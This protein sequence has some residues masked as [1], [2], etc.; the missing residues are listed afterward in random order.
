M[1]R[2]RGLS[3]RFT[4]WVL[5]VLLLT[6][7]GAAV[8]SMRAERQRLIEEARERALLLNRTADRAI[9]SAM[10]LGGREGAC[11]FVESLVTGHDID[12]V[13]II[14]QEGVVSL[15]PSSGEE[16]TTVPYHALKWDLALPGGG[17]DSVRV[18][19]L[20]DESGGLRV[21][22]IRPI[23]NQSQCWTAS[24]HAHNEDERVLGILD[25]GWYVE[26]F[27]GELWER[28]IGTV[29]G[30]G[31]ATFLATVLI[32][33]LLYVVVVGPIRSALESVRGM[34]RGRFAERI[35]TEG[36]DEVRDLVAAFN[37]MSL[38]LEESLRENERWS[39][40][41]VRKVRASTEELQRVNQDLAKTT[42]KLRDLDRVKSEFMRRV[43][44]EL[45]SP[46]AA[47]Q[48]TL[49][50][51]TGGFTRAIDE[52]SVD[53]VTRAERRT[54]GLLSLLDDLLDLSRLTEGDALSRMEWFSVADVL[55]DKLELVRDEAR[56]KGLTIELEREE[57]LPDLVGERRNF[58]HLISNLLGNALRYT[59][60][61]GRITVT[62][63]TEGGMLVLEVED[64]GIG[65]PEA[66][67]T[68]IFDDF[69]RGERAK[70]YR[71][72]G[73]GLGLSIVRQVI[74][75]YGGRIEVESTV[76]RGT[77]FTVRLPTAEDWG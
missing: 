40:E 13:R 11:Q 68:R 59:P 16:G 50:V 55:T 62:A 71:S 34:A 48:S 32:G 29:G 8:L 10:L 33:L 58:D 66:E 6:G 72:E 7:A 35:T 54:E 27:R 12:H 38:D 36:L 23:L 39:V 43:E 74:G 64:T 5:A 20:P 56:A 67:M 69:Y 28:T 25:M 60:P 63:R 18:I 3:F 53:L 42:E 30:I 1:M 70:R 19:A 76:G 31:V 46:L 2:F 41:L 17:G 4:L 15:S 47:I 44:H 75:A 52:K 73:T 37:T 65:I 57:G 24:C 49:R 22:A 51:V 45:R 21:R 61:G 14:S 9:A 77:R 26:D